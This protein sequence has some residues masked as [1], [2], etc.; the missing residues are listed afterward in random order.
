[1]RMLITIYHRLLI[2]VAAGVL[3]TA[4]GVAQ[5]HLTNQLDEK[6]L[7]CDGKPAYLRAYDLSPDGERLAILTSPLALFN[8]PNAPSCLGIWEMASQRTLKSVDV[9][10]HQ[11]PPGSGFSPQVLF[12]QHGK[13][14]VLQ[15]QKTISIYNADNLAQ[16]RQIETPK[17]SFQTPLQVLYAS[18]AN[19]LL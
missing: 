4:S 8:Q 13:G 3:F 11:S 19:I 5:I 6:G 16:T 14:L 1:S 18:E 10:V 2:S 12:V 9:E 17:E 7:T 15:N